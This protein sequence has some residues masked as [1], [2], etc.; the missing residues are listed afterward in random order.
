MM[1]GAPKIGV[2]AFSGITPDSP[3]STQIKLQNKANAP[4]ASSVTG[5]SE[6]W[7]EV[8]NIKRAK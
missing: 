4:P 1:T 5:I 2:T 7:L 3:G 8:P 6:L